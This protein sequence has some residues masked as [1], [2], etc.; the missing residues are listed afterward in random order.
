MWATHSWGGKTKINTIHPNWI[1]SLFLNTLRSFLILYLESIYRKCWQFQ[2]KYQEIFFLN[3]LI[4]T[5][6]AKLF[7][8][9]SFTYPVGQTPLPASWKSHCWAAGWSQWHR[10]A[11]AV[12]EEEF[13][14]SR[15]LF[16]LCGVY[17]TI[18]AGLSAI[19]PS[20]V[21]MQTLTRWHQDWLSVSTGALE[22]SKLQGLTFICF[23]QIMLNILHVWYIARFGKRFKKRIILLQTSPWT[24]AS[25]KNVGS[26][27]S[28][29]FYPT[30]APAPAWPAATGLTW[31]LQQHPPLCQPGWSGHTRA[32]P[33]TEAAPK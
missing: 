3:F 10:L 5:I 4:N 7:L 19:F 2:G 6:F 18:T 30:A 1:K 13:T 22:L 14:G 21:L 9:D 11:R 16:L 27:D 20:F 25:G 29:Q 31:I 15:N 8:K 33:G 23:P 32:S 24:S 28:M 17:L 12:H 26:S